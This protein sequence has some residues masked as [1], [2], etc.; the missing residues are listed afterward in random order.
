MQVNTTVTNVFLFT[1]LGKLV[2][3]LASKKSQRGFNQS[4]PPSKNETA[5]KY[6]TLFNLCSIFGTIN[7]AQ[8]TL[9]HLE[10]AGEV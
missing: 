4:D 9:K 3:Q 5:I 8:S 7:E 2:V 10:H 6:P 1:V